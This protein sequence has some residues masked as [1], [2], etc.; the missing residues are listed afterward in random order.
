MTSCEFCGDRA[1][2]I[3][4]RWC[5]PSR[6]AAGHLGW[7]IVRPDSDPVDD[8]RPVAAATPESVAT[9]EVR[10]TIHSV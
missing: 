7:R 3:D 9:V 10:V 8:P 6:E 1:A 4:G 2:T 5:S